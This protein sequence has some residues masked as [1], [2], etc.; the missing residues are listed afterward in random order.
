MYGETAGEGI[1]GSEMDVELLICPP[2]FAYPKYI[3]LV[4]KFWPVIPFKFQK[5]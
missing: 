1:S 2:V 4:R 5:H 3:L